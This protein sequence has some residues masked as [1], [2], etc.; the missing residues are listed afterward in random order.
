MAVRNQD[1]GGIAVPIAG[2]LAGS[3]LQPIDL[4]FG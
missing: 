3:L 1:H 4:S 2:P